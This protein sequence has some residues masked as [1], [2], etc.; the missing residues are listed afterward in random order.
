MFDWFDSISLPTLK[1]LSNMKN[2]AIQKIAALEVKGVYWGRRF[3]L[4][5]F[6]E[7]ALFRFLRE[8]A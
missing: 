1:D 5:E 3:G 2:L 6:E 8:K 4:D 7:D